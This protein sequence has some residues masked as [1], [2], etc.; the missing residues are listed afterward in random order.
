MNK[1]LVGFAIVAAAA[2]A[3]GAWYWSRPAPNDKELVLYGNVDLRQ[4]ALAFPSSERI[5]RVLVEEGQ[6][7]RP[8]QVL[9]ELDTRGL[10]LRLAEAEAQAAAQQQALAR[11]KAG[12][13]SEE[14]AQA[15]ARTGAAQ[16]EADLARQQLERV[17]AVQQDSN[18]RAVSQQDVDAARARAKS[19]QAA[20]EQAR[21]AQELAQH[22]PRRED[23]A[24]AQA[25]L[26]AANAAVALLQYQLGEAS[27]KAPVDAV[28][29]ARL[30]EAGDM[31]S[32]QR[33][34][35][36]LAIADP[37]W[38]RTYVREADLGRVRPGVAASIS[39]DSQPGKALA[40]KVGY[41]SSVAE[42]TPKS[43]QTEELRTA[44]VYE[45][46]V[47][48]D[49]K[50]DVLRMGMPATVRIATGH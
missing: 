27:L 4:V 43:V 9:A 32:P 2:I 23:I 3:A 19:A 35:Y 15:R 44:L 1:K 31:A 10:R 7:V 40:G 18:G 42:F 34:V 12:T 48:A 25:Q 45:V 38:V 30:M 24:Q 46:R 37:K 28:V 33:P 29:R 39:I 14:L 5:A 16:A 22:G 41:I 6:K 20:L 50:A 17:L 13:R 49:D 21:Q 11:L 8:G 26:D 47:L 36:T